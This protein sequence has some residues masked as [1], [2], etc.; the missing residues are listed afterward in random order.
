MTI[1]Q[2]ID[3][4]IVDKIQKLFA[5]AERAKGNENEAQVAMDKAQELLVKYNLDLATVQ[6]HA[7]KS[8]TAADT[9]KRD[10]AKV[11]RSAMYEWQQQ[12]VNTIAT[13]NFCVHWITTESQEYNK[14]Y[15]WGMEKAYRAVKRHK[16]LGREANVAVVLNMVDY[17]F[18]TIERLLEIPFPNNK[19][20]L[21]RAAIS[22]RMGVAERLRER[23]KHKYEEM[24]QA[25]YATQ[26]E[27]VYSTA[28]A[29]R[30]VDEAEEIANYDFRYGQGA[31]LAAQERSKRWEIEYKEKADREAAEHAALLAS[32]TPVQKARREAE[33]RKQAEKDA[34]ASER[35]WRRYQ[36]EQEAREARIDY[37]AVAAG[38]KVGDTISLNGQLKTSTE[39]GRL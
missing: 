37:T 29:V 34:K 3:A 11:N 33:E 4:S 17:L 14:R 8:G 21:S 36:R 16:I 35:Y 23:I 39:K 13:C 7:K 9:G 22:W 15:S 5:M 18:E 28:L 1:P 12:L 31:W 32:E 10:Y 2:G 6:E 26:G 30:R 19:D 24:R 38:R 20:R 25:D 27:Q